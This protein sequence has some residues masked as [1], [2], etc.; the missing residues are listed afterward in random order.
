M[1]IASTGSILKTALEQERHKYERLNS[2]VFN[3]LTPYSG[4]GA[5][6]S[7]FVNRAGGEGVEL[8]CAGSDKEKPQEHHRC[9]Q[10]EQ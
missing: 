1:Q 5:G 3:V 6:V 10:Q 8:G 7:G 4:T 2:I 9:G